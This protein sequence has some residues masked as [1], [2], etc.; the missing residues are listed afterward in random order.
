[1]GL[2]LLAAFSSAAFC[3]GVFSAWAAKTPEP[4]P[5]AAIMPAAPKTPRRM[6]SRRDTC[7]G[8]PRPWFVFM[9]SVLLLPL[10]LSRQEIDRFTVRRAASAI[11]AAEE[12]QGY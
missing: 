2:H 1:L 11:N 5:P 10:R 7:S 6:T 4:R 9:I 8:L 12:T 3:S